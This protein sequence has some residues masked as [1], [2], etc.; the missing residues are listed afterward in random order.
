M[1]LGTIQTHL[2]NNQ[3]DFEDRQSFSGL[4]VKHEPPHVAGRYSQLSKEN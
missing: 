4:G 2:Q 1:E 3:K